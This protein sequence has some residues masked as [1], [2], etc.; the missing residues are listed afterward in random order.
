MCS[1]FDRKLA[2]DL[3]ALIYEA[4]GGLLALAA[5]VAYFIGPVDLLSIIL[6]LTCFSFYIAVM[7]QQK[8]LVP[9]SRI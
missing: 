2:V 9:Y 6:L 4:N 3:Y 8:I 5:V 7:K 1:I